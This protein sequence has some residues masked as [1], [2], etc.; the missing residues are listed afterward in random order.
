MWMGGGGGGGVDGRRFSMSVCHAGV[1]MELLF[2]HVLS[3]TNL[4]QV[5]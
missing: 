1:C 5:L 2:S 4:N 3:S